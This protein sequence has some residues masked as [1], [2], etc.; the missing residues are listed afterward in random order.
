[1]RLRCIPQSVAANCDNA[2]A[3]ERATASIV[4]LCGHLYQH[5]RSLQQVRLAELAHGSGARQHMWALGVHLRT[6]GC[7]LAS[8]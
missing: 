6:V 8:W 2:G 5:N 3:A 1:M 7:P 4:R